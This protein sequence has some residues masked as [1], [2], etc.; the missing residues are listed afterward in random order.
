[1]TKQIP[2]PPDQTC[3]FLR[4]QD[5]LLINA[6]RPRESPGV[7]RPQRLVDLVSASVFTWRK[8]LPL[9]VRLASR[10]PDSVLVSA[11]SSTGEGLLRSEEHTSELQSHVNL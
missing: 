2:R 9:G 4:G 5:H 6:E 11:A 7:S 10:W 8:G 1:M 3:I